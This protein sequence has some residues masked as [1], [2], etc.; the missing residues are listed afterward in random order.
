MSKKI[1]LLVVFLFCFAL[2]YTKAQR[3]SADSSL[4]G[5]WKGTSICQVK[6]SPCHDEVVVYHISKAQGTD[7]FNILANKIVNDTEEEMGILSFK[8]DKNNNKLI[9]T[10][11]NGLWT[12]N[13]KSKDL[14][15]TLIVRG[16]LYRII[17]VSKQP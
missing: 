10:S 2:Q 8:F 1:S 7:M 16:E 6:S 5:T 14:E 15:G 11:Y 12:F 9:S 17:K 13:L 4:I 3:A